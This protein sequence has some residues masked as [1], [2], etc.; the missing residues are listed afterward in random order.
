[1]A[2]TSTLAVEGMSCQHCVDAVESEV[3]RVPAVRGVEVDLATGRVTVTSDE[4]V[5]PALLEA[6]VREAGYEVAV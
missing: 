5:D 2:S 1:M 3:G 6:A 4:P